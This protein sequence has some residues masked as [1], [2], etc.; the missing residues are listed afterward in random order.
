[1]PR[2]SIDKALQEGICSLIDFR[3]GRNYGIYSGVV[4]GESCRVFGGIYKEMIALF[5]ILNCVDFSLLFNL[6]LISDNRL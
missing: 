3:V 1:M 2:E 4:A 5:A 6:R